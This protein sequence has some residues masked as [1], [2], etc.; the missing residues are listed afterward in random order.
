[1]ILVNQD[2]LR[3]V[4]HDHRTGTSSKTGNPYEICNLTLSDGLESQELRFQNT[5][6]H[7]LNTLVRG[8]QVTIKVNIEKTFNNDSVTVIGIDKVK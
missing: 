5:L 6:L 8:D 7:T 4:K 3:Y 1:M 2:T